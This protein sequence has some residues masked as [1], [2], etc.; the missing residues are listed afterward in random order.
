MTRGVTPAS[1]VTDWTKTN[2]NPG[3][4]VV[5]GVV[6]GAWFRA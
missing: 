5:A 6:P 2:T 1:D 3:S 4:T